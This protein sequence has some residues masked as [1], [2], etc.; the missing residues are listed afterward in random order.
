MRCVVPAALAGQRLDRA[1]AT[2]T[3]LSRSVVGKLLAD[4]AITC[5]GEPAATAA[6]RV[7]TDQQIDI[8]PGQL[9]TVT[10][11]KNA[12][13]AP[14]PSE[15]IEFEVLH[16]DE[17]IVVVDKPAGLVTHPGA[18]HHTDTLLNGLL[19]R[20]PDMADAGPSERPG[21][22]HRLD[23]DTSGLLV[24]ARTEIAHHH[25][26]TRLAE[27]AVVRRYVTFV[28]GVP[29]ATRGTIDAP[30][31]RSHRQRTKMRIRPD[32]REAR[33][34]YMVLGSAECNGLTPPVATAL[35]CLLQT[36]RT[37]QIRVHLAG[38]GLPVLG[39]LVYGC[40]DP[41]GANRQLLH[42]IALA[43]DHPCTGEPLAFT[44]ELPA[45]L[46]AAAQALGLTEQ[47]NCHHA[48]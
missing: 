12:K 20:F 39:D 30:I 31:G 11:A 43:F 9:N 45:D 24:C 34:D 19:W 5:A 37:H 38:I 22:V 2:L 13:T 14:Q 17:H 48:T 32:G 26:T 33:T 23:R 28:R 40:P 10:A 29:E 18:G 7:T 25:L 41:F 35:S 36:G 15:E 8:D 3:G 1:V 46:R 42:A 4:G 6:D 47:L 21:I 16:S 44:S 27:R